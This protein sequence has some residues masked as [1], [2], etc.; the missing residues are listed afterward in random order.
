MTSQVKCRIW[1]TCSLSP[2]I[3]EALQVPNR[4]N[5]D[6]VEVELIP[7]TL[8]DKSGDKSPHSKREAHRP[9]FDQAARDSSITWW[10]QPLSSFCLE[11]SSGRPKDC[12]RPLSLS[13]VW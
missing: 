13:D 5:Q 3:L 4:L 6:D 1:S 9:V 12:R 7:G 11:L 2:V 10:K 8:W